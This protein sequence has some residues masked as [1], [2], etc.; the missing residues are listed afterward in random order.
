LTRRANHRHIFI[1][2][3]IKK[4]R[5]GKPAAGFFIWTAIGISQSQSSGRHSSDP[6]APGSRSLEH[7]PL[8]SSAQIISEFSTFGD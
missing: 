8:P 1:I 2:A 7:L 3:R 4:A 5:A 6:L